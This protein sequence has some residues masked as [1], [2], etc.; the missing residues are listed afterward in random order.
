MELIPYEDLKA[1]QIEELSAPGKLIAKQAF[2]W[3][4]EADHML[5]RFLSWSD[6][7]RTP[8]EPGIVLPELRQALAEVIL[9]FDDYRK[10]EAELLTSSLYTQATQTEV[11]SYDDEPGAP[12]VDVFTSGPLKRALPEVWLNSIKPVLGID[13]GRCDPRYPDFRAYQ[14]AFELTETGTLTPS[15]LE[16]ELR[17]IHE[18][19]EHR[20]PILPDDDYN[21]EI[22]ARAYTFLVRLIGGCPGVVSKRQD[23]LGIAFAFTQ[24]Y[25]AELLCTISQNLRP[26]DTSDF[27]ESVHHQTQILY[28]RDASSEE[29]MIFQDA[30]ATCIG[31]D[32]TADGAARS[33]CVA[34]LTSAE[35]LFY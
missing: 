16:T 23:S 22:P 31:Q 33:V 19:L 15:Q 6:G 26:N 18:L 13:F 14:E 1:W 32:C 4:A 17:R 8:R 21:I 24:D 30:F 27:E 10:A 20:V 34:L 11:D 25:L 7:G 9:T 12:I 3:E 2:L 28:G 5:N 35:M 29:V